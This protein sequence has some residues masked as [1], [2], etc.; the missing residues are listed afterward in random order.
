LYKARIKGY[1]AELIPRIVFH[2]NSPG[3][4]AMERSSIGDGVEPSPVTPGP[5]LTALQLA[6]VSGL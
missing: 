6:P 2:H 5:P 4:A 3:L 1:F